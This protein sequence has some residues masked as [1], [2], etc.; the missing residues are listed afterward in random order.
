[1][2]ASGAQADLIRSSPDIAREAAAQNAGSLLPQPAQNVASS[3][4]TVRQSLQ[5]HHRLVALQPHPQHARETREGVDEKRATLAKVG[6]W[7]EIPRPFV[8]RRRGAVCTATLI[9]PDARPCHSARLV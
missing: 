7:H 1:M 6:L 4:L 3:R 2:A 5:N 9:A 8:R